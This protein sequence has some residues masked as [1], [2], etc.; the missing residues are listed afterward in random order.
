MR[1]AAL[2]I[3]VLAAAPAAA[4]TDFTALTPAERAIFHAEIRAVLLA[5]PELTRPAPPVQPDLYAEDVASD[6]AL[7]GAETARL[8]APDLPGFGPPGAANRIALFTG[9]DCPDCARA[10]AELRDLAQ[11]HDLRVTLFD[12]AAQPDLA[13]RLGVDTLPF[14]VLPKMM[15]RGHMPAPVLARYLDNRTGQ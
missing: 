8:F 7:I 14:Y 3:L 4:G 10:E 13:A 15:L 9:P 12:R 2:L 1:R 5:H 6:L 11:G